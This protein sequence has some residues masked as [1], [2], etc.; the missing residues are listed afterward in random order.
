LEPLERRYFL[1][2]VPIDATAGVPFEGLVATNLR[3]PAH[4]TGLALVNVMIN[5][6]WD[7]AP[8]AVARADGT[9]DLYSSMTVQRSGTDD[10]IILFRND[11]TGGWDVLERGPQTVKPNHFDARVPDSSVYNRVPGT[12]FRGAVAT[13]NT[14]PLT[15]SLD[16]YVVEVEGLGAARQGRLV[17]E[18]DGS[19]GVY[20]DD[21]YLPV[22][23]SAGDVRVTIRLANA[24]PDAPD[25][26]FARVGLSVNP[27]IGI[28]V[29]YGAMTSDTGFRIDLPNE[30]K[31]AESVYHY[32]IP[33]AESDGWESTFAVDLI[34]HTGRDVQPTTPATLVRNADGSY[35]IVGELADAVYYPQMKIRETIHR[36]AVDGMPAQTYTVEYVGSFDI[37]ASI[38]SDTP[39]VDPPAE[40][41]TGGETPTD[42]VPPHFG[43]GELGGSIDES[44][45]TALASRGGSALNS[46]G[47]DTLVASL[48]SSSRD[49]T[50][51][52]DADAD[53]DDAN[54]APLPA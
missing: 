10:M 20:V 19:V 16:Q 26:G 13:F 32:F 50:L 47:F 8:N 14:T 17:R 11:L 37:V 4:A 44:R 51:S 5:G 46:D 21:T 15:Q 42:P 31:H 22:G 54:E 27:S 41:G 36:P 24:S 28:G 2:I 30:P 3:L 53:A 1:T 35:A 9:F 39:V 18:G 6:Q 25:A 43:L 7:Y 45:F 52:A 34:W 48:F 23:D 49:D 29:F 12:Q 40:N 33:A 38:P